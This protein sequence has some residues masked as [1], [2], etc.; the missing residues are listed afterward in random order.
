MK[1]IDDLVI[2]IKEKE[3]IIGKN[4]IVKNPVFS[5]L[6]SKKAP[7]IIYGA[8]ALGH[9]VYDILIRN[10]VAPQYF[11]SGLK[12]GYIDSLTGIEV[13]GKEKLT[14]YNKGTVILSI[15]DAAS[16]EE[17]EEIERNLLAMGFEESQVMSH[18]VFEEKIS[19]SFLLEHIQEISDVYHLLSDEES[20]R[21]YMQKLE[22]M[23]EYI[24]VRFE[25]FQT[26]YIDRDIINF[27]NKEVIID[28][29][30]YNGDSASLFR[31]RV[32]MSAAIYSFEPDSSNYD[33]LKKRVYNDSKIYPEKIG[34]WKCKDT[35]R[36]SD[37]C[38]G[39]SHVE[40]G[41]VFEIQVMDLD[42]YCREKD[43]I[44]TYI[45]MDIEGA[46]MEALLGAQ[47]NIKNNKP[48]LA[49]CL[50]HKK[51]DIFAIPLLVH[52]MNPSYK[53]YIRH[54]SNYRTDTLLYA[55]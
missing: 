41:G 15:G 10:N 24:P 42:T 31:D 27:D 49:I 47:G 37:D 28:A 11:C 6:L 51:E 8:G 2:Y 17:K 34:L 30:A 4:A 32:G 50:Y 52:K 21:V 13:I 36:F 9:A 14:S 22:Y 25:S 46:E 55:V 3:E 1:T 18:V 5:M 19:P 54:Y 38:N 23:V 48:K 29:G 26:M 20:R 53:M 33:E 44:P 45:K 43:I 16:R 35:L 39:S 7:V 12:N 40:R